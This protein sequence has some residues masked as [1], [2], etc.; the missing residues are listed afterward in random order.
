MKRVQYIAIA[1][2]LCLTG[3][4]PNPTAELPVDDFT[5]AVFGEEFTATWCVYCPSAAENLMKVYEDIPDEPYYHDKF[6]FVALIT[7]VNDKAE[8]RMDDYP[9]VTGYPTVIFDG[10]DEKVS[11][12][13]SDTS[14]YEQAIDNCGQRDDTDISLDIAMEHLGADQLGVSVTMTWNEDAAFG[15][16]TFNGYVRAYIVE[17]VSRYN[18][19]DGNPYHFGF[20]DYA[21]EESVELEPHESKELTTVWTGGDH[22]D[23]NGNDFSDID[24]ENI[25]IFVAFFNDESA[26]TDK[27]VLETAFAIPPELELEDFDEIVGGEL[28]IHASAIS[29][30]SEINNVFY[31]WD[32]NDWHDSGLGEF[33]G[34]FSLLIDTETVDNGEHELA[35]MVVD[36]GASMVKTINLDILNDDNPPIL[37][38]ISPNEGE[39]VEDV[40]VLEV[41]ATDDNQVSNVEYRVNQENWRKMYYNEDDSYIASWNTQGANAG[42]GEHQ[43][44]FRAS[45]LTPNWAQKSVNITVFNEEDITYPYLEIVMPK[46]EFYN[47]RINIEVEA[48]DPDGISTVQYRIDNGTWRTLDTDNSDIFIG[49]WTP[50]GDGWHWLDVRAEDSQGYVTEQA[51]RFET[52]STPPFI[53]LESITDDISA[54]AEFNLNVQDY[55]SIF[56][57]KY[58][59]NGEAWINLDHDVENVDFTWD[60]TKYEDG[61]CLMEIECIDRWGGVSTLYRNLDVK[62]KGLIYSVAPSNVNTGVVTKVSAIIDYENPESVSM[63]IAKTAEGVLADGQKIPMYKEGNYYYGDLFFEH[64]GFYIYS[65]EVDTGHGKLSS[66]EQTIMV[67]AQQEVVKSDEENMLSG[68]GLLPLLFLICFIVLRRRD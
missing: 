5:H 31:R 28:E 54:I 14:N 41:E 32:Q 45:D 57:L 35:I 60:S 67:S 26:S 39:T 20:L 15:D 11:G 33:N 13:Q 30:K 4:T 36:K 55:S 3:V 19:Y 29:E 23:K 10:N 64:E 47:S 59:I 9:D 52:D 51:I 53:I 37:E 34:D 56:S 22:E 66:Y 58:R 24:Y 40:I 6:F 27:Y 62:N 68:P 44:T 17:K 50:F 63:I 12:G 21:F 43:I 61:E 18:N 46:E 1:L 49:T 25:N 48:S 2:I 7:D 42:N 8:E 65:I 16:P 38:I